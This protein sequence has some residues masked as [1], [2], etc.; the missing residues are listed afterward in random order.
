MFK[1]VIEN[2]KIRTFIG[3]K[4]NERKKSQ[5]LF[6]TVK[7]NYNLSKKLNADNIK[8][9][10]DYSAIIKYL[11]KFIKNSRYKTLEKLILETKNNL[12]NQF[13]LDNVSLKINKSEVAKKYG[14]DSLSVSE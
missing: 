12:K 5:I 2:L 11:K 4:A 6:I 13:K 14:C 8:N 3:I 7:F 10:K 9:L 1:V